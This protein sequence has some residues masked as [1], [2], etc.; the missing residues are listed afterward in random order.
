M[1]VGNALVTSKQVETHASHIYT[2]HLVL[3]A[4]LMRLSTPYPYK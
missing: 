4:H 2:T 1:Y 3:T